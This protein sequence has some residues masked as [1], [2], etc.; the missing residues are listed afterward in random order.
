MFL[1]VH[2]A[3]SDSYCL[4][5]LKNNNAKFLQKSKQIMLQYREQISFENYFYVA[6][7][8]QVMFLLLREDT[9]HHSLL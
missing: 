1:C 4:Y 5:S 9:D 8:S 6:I 7:L 3:K 2:V